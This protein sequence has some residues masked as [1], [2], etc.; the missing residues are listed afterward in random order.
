MNKKLFLKYKWSGLVFSL[1]IFGVNNN[2]AKSSVHALDMAQA[3]QANRYNVGNTPIAQIENRK[4]SEDQFTQTEALLQIKSVRDFMAKESSSRYIPYMN[5]IAD[6][7]AKEV[8]FKDSHYVFYH[9]T[10]NVWRLPQDVYTQLYNFFTPANAQAKDFAFL[11]FNDIQGPRAQDFLVQELKKNGLVDDNG[12]VRALLLSVNLSLFGNTSFPSEC[13]WEYFLRERAHGSPDRKIY[14]SIMDKWGLTHQ[15]IG[16]LMDLIKLIDTKEKT[17]IQIFVPQNKIDDIGYLAWATG[18]PGHVETI[19][20]VRK[21]VK[22]KV[23][24]GKVDPEDNQYKAGA[25]WAMWDLADNFKKE[26]EANP[27][28]KDIMDGIKKGDFSLNKYLKR[29][30]NTPWD[31]PNIN[32]GQARLIF[33]N[34]VLLNPQSGVKFYRYSTAERQKMQEYTKRLKQII[35]KIIASRKGA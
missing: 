12:E 1:T 14:E 3:Q 11:R 5:I 30:R 23:Y 15:Y 16:E 20:W 22:N 27:M 10:D 13:T 7:L 35:D 25:L 24:K 18:I 34:S 31:I 33:S 21:N 32:Y 28:F 6:C 19:D 8:E 2:L 9:T 29:Y 17:L 26:Q 4:G